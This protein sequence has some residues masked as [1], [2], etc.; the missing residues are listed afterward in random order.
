MFTQH[1][2]TSRSE[3]ASYWLLLALI[4]FLPICTIPLAFVSTQIAKLGVGALLVL[5]AG[6]LYAIGRI[7]IQEVTFPKSYLLY[8]LW[9]MP[10]V[11]T[12]ATFFS[13]NPAVRFGG[14]QL[15]IDT[16]GFMTVLA[17]AGTLAALVA[18]DMRHILGVYAALLLGAIVFIAA[19]LAVY[20][21]GVD[22][23]SSVTLI[24]SLKDAALFFGL[25]IIGVLFALLLLPV[26]ALLRALLYAVLV[27]ALFFLAV[28]NLPVVWQIF[29]AVSLG[30]VV[31]QF[32]AREKKDRGFSFAPVLVL[33]V[34]AFFLFSGEYLS[35]S[36]A[37]MMQ[38]GELDVRPLWSTTVGITKDVWSEDMLLGAGP[39]RFGEVWSLHMPSRIQGTDFWN[40]DFAFGF[41]TIPTSF[42]TTGAL[43]LLAWAVFLAL[44][45]FSGVRSFLQAKGGT[46]KPLVQYVSVTSFVGAVYLWGMAFFQNVSPVLLMYAAVLTG[47][48]IG[49][50]MMQGEI[51]QMHI[52]FGEKPQIGFLVTLCISL[53]VVAALGGMYQTSQRLYAESAYQ[54]AL[55]AVQEDGDLEQAGVLVMRAIGIYPLDVYYRFK[56]SLDFANL[57]QMLRSPEETVE[58]VQER[59]QLLLSSSVDDAKKATFSDPQDYRNW[60]A[61]A[62]LYQNLTILK[63]EGAREEAYTAFDKVLTLRPFS[64]SVYLAKATME[65]AAGN[66]AAA[67]GLVEQAITMRNNYADAVFLLAQMQL[68]NGEMENVLR[69]V[70]AITMFDPQNY[71]AHF[72][73]GLLHYWNGE[74]EAARGSFERSA[75]LNPSYANAHYFLG[76][77]YWREGRTAQALEEMQIVL[78]TN[79]DNADVMRHVADITAGKRAPQT[80]AQQDIATTDSVLGDEIIEG[81][82]IDGIFE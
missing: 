74:F 69:S 73:L 39:G 75:A 41:G 40:A 50:R 43:G 55:R 49:A 34:C 26:T 9:G 31:W 21:F 1:T 79:P 80:E 24:G 14:E 2:K 53:F 60:L 7:R 13:G 59:S 78:E 77:T 32:T 47:V 51:R 6:V 58:S 70:Q 25:A 5:L 22:I 61:L 44:L 72:K 15:A 48:F 18:R 12:L 76:L 28:A 57:Q 45:V 56:S 8:S 16:A 64:P 4:A 66:N 63:L 46:T 30:I 36:V 52:E 42:V 81:S 35:G 23:T 82:I 37:R 33:V 20:V 54:Y 65:R 67:R 11:Y 3:V 38:V 19:Q 10:L 71:T 29:G 17:V 62:S 68:E 27:G